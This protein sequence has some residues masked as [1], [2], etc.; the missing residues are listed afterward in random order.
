MSQP[1]DASDLIAAARHAEPGAV[2][3]LLTVYRSYLALLAEVWS[4]RCPNGK[5]DP[6]DL[7]QETLL[8]AMTRLKG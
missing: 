5:A 2:D 1:R 3:R 6:S 7:V 8:K 4:K